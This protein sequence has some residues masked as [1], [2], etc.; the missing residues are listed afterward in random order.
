MT[1][2]PAMAIG[3]WKARKMPALPRTSA[4]QEV[5]SS[6]LKRMAPEVTSYS[7]L[8]SRTL[9]S[10][11]LPDPLGPIRAWTSPA[12]TTR[13]RPRRISAPSALTCRSSISSRGALTRAS[14][15]VLR[16]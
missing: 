13:S 8:P 16:R 2:T 4:P 11:D 3:Y 5:M 9:A 12:G 6:P 14:V 7:G 15:L 1:D 10:V